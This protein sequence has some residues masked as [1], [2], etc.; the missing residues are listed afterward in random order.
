MEKFRVTREKKSL[1]STFG[2]IEISNDNELLHLA[3]GH[4]V[5][6]LLG[7]KIAYIGQLDS[8][9]K[10]SEIALQLLNLELSDTKIY[11]LTDAI[12]KHAAEWLAEEDLRDDISEHPV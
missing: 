9:E 11:R 1:S 12:G 6:P 2:R 8:Y 5:S 10:G 4:R 3:T 7:E